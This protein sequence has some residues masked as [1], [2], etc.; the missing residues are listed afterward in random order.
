MRHEV[1]ETSLQISRRWAPNGQLL[2]VLFIDFCH[3]LKRWAVI[4][5]FR[6]AFCHLRHLSIGSVGLDGGRGLGNA[7]AC[8]SKKPDRSTLSLREKK[9][10]FL[11]D[12]T[13]LSNMWVRPVSALSPQFCHKSCLMRNGSCGRSAGLWVGH[14]GTLSAPLLLPSQPLVPSSTPECFFMSLAFREVLL[15]ASVYELMTLRC[16]PM[17]TRCQHGGS[18]AA[19]A[20][21]WQ[22]SVAFWSRRNKSLKAAF[23]GQ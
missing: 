14:S 1:W 4:A 15:C 16:P 11:P 13:V 3:Y 7:A 23:C 20:P 22:W 12:E 18:G 19:K 6:T 8:F 9:H 2:F 10:L 21:I 17:E 5:V